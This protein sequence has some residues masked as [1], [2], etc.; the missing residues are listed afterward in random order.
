MSG[1][2]DVSAGVYMQ[3]LRIQNLHIQRAGWGRA[4]QGE[5]T[6]ERLAG[7][8]EQVSSGAGLDEVGTSRRG[9]GRGRARRACRNAGGAQRCT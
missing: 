1:S 3:T 6:A 9:A 7:Q 4:G 5:G 8:S 2:K